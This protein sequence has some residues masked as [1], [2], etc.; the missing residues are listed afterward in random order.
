M[1]HIRSDHSDLINDP[2]LMGRPFAPI[3]L[4]TAP[5]RTLPISKTAS[6]ARKP[7]NSLS[8]TSLN[9][10]HMAGSGACF[11]EATLKAPH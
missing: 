10:G 4:A 1:T 6:G 8:V 3:E 5:K 2:Y 7:L 11:I 9:H